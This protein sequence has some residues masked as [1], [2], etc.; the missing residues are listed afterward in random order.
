MKDTS[1]SSVDTGICVD[2]TEKVNLGVPTPSRCSEDSGN[3]SSGSVCITP[4]P[5]HSPAMAPHKVSSTLPPKLDYKHTH[6]DELDQLLQVERR[7]D[8]TDKMYQTMP[9]CLPSQSSVDDSESISISHSGSHSE[10]CNTLSQSSTTSPQDQKSQL[11]MELP[12]DGIANDATLKPPAPDKNSPHEQLHYAEFDNSCDESTLKPNSDVD[13]KKLLD[14][15][16][17]MP[18]DQEAMSRSLNEDTL[19]ANSPIDPKKIN[20]S[21][22]LY[23]D[24]MVRSMN[25]NEY[26]DNTDNFSLNCENKLEEMFAENA[27]FNDDYPRGTLRRVKNYEEK[28]S[29]EKDSAKK[30]D[31]LPKNDASAYNRAISM[32][33]SWIGSLDDSTSSANDSNYE[34]SRSISGPEQFNRQTNEVSMIYI[35]KCLFYAMDNLFKNMPQ[36]C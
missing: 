22:K 36:Q 5:P 31:Q 26:Y 12:L 7:V 28:I 23:S 34:L 17:L 35:H 18:L 13:I 3:Q 8:D 16:D 29:K 33:N 4:T 9:A 20:D 14:R 19:K 2:G 24:I 25:S 1:C 21:L 11:C 32:D 15:N 27:Y 30:P 6:W 10:I